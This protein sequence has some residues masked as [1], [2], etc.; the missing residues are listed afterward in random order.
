MDDLP[1]IESNIR[2]ARIVP[3]FVV[4]DLSSSL[5]FWR[6]LLG[7]RVLYERPEE[8]FVYLDRDGVQVMLLMDT[9]W[10]TGVLQRPYGRG[11]NFQIEVAA[12]MPLLSSL[13]S[14]SWQLYFEPEE[15]WYRCG[16]IEAGQRQFLVQDPDGY[17]LRF[18][19]SL[20]ERP[21][22]R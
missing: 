1:P 20:G 21:L 15:K 8:R 5:Y 13:R 14:A 17:L 16:R 7:F 19:E 10:H 11:I 12:L 6:D 9:D 4:S 22:Q 3:E 18:A 2:W